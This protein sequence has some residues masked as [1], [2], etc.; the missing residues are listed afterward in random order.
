[1]N[2]QEQSSTLLLEADIPAPTMPAAD[3]L[4]FL[5]PRDEPMFALPTGLRHCKACA[6]PMRSDNE[7]ELCS[8]CRG[9]KV[10]AGREHC[11]ICNKP[12]NKGN[13][14]GYCTRHFHLSRPCHTRAVAA[15]DLAET[16]AK[17]LTAPKKCKNCGGDVRSDNKTFNSETPLCGDCNW[18][19]RP[20]NM[21]AHTRAEARRCK[22]GE[23]CTGKEADGK[24][25]KLGNNN[26]S[27]LCALC[28]GRIYGSTPEIKTARKR[29]TAAYRK[30][31]EKKLAEIKAQAEAAREFKLALVKTQAKLE[32][33]KEKRRG[34][35]KEDHQK[36]ETKIG[37]Q[38]E[39]CI[40]IFARLFAHPE[41]ARDPR[42]RLLN[43][44]GTPEFSDQ[45]KDAAR[46]AAVSNALPEDRPVTAARYF[47]AEKTGMSYDTVK[48]LHNRYLA[49]S[50]SKKT[51]S[52]PA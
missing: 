9:K 46:R 49:R 16:Q 52:V 14:T 22:E 11:K 17:E 41:L 4:A 10:E 47:I 38:V 18:V 24:S 28:W 27:G 26:K 36:Q 35:N 25:A 51:S 21:Q 19:V 29:N 3:A 8:T 50:A 6:N 12:L 7:D 32:E 5:F 1:M 31:Q 45:E 48:R 30:R 2:E 20:K 42:R 13:R 43:G 44:W 39:D 40:P 33:E 23:R 15:Q 34:K 37:S